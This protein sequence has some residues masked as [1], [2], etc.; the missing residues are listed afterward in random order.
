MT[1]P[2]PTRAALR[3][4]GRLTRRG[5]AATSLGAALLVA[6]TVLGYP[7]LL[8]LG[9]GLLVMA[10]GS[11]ALVGWPRAVDVSRVIVPLEVA[12]NAACAV[13]VTIV[14]RGRWSRIQLEAADQVDGQPIPARPLRATAGGSAR[15][16]YELPTG[17]RGVLRVGPLTCGGPPRPDWRPESRAPSC[18]PRSGCCPGYC[19]CGGCPLASGTATP[20]PRTGWPPAAPAW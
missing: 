17:R 6:G 9:L 16:H 1:S 5:A 8:V 7:G 15:T 18:P 11:L 10:A 3:L 2:P 13:T 20:P 4:R 14:D 19:R 12:R